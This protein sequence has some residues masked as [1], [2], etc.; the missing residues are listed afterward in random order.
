MPSAQEIAL[1]VWG[2][3]NPALDGRDMRQIVADTEN[4]AANIPGGNYWG[5]LIGAV[6]KIN[7]GVAD[8]TTRPAADIA[9]QL[10]AA[11]IAAAVRDELVALLEGKK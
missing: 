6:D 1:A 4:R 5:D 3:T 2:Y 10:D 8:L 11:G 9:K 7:T